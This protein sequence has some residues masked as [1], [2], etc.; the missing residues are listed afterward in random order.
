VIFIFSL[1]NI[2]TGKI[3]CANGFDEQH[4]HELEENECNLATEYRCRNGQCIDKEFY[5]NEQVDCMDHS[6]EINFYSQ[7]CYTDYTV[8]CEDKPCPP[9]FFSCGDGVCYDGPNMINISCKSQRDRLY[10]NKMSQSTLI[11]FPHITLIYGNMTSIVICFNKT[12]CPYLSNNTTSFVMQNST[13]RLLSTFT[14][15][16][17]IHFDD[18]LRDVRRFVR[19]C[20]SS[21]SEQYQSSNNSTLFQCDDKITFISNSR[22]SDGHNDC[23]NG[24]DEHPGIVCSLNLPYRLMCDNGTRCIPIPLIANGIVSNFLLRTVYTYKLLD[25]NKFLNLYSKD[26]YCRFQK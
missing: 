25:Q 23:S 20:S 21:L 24:E 11:L 16:I 10:F 18:M 8:I 7:Q 19:S 3:D 22:L 6:D 15:Q 4:C 5:W 1:E 17:Y 26:N 12:L 2:F 14:N 9:L 13:C